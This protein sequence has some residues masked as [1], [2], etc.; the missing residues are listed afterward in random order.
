MN[1]HSFTFIILVE[2]SYQTS[3]WDKGH[4]GNDG[5]FGNNLAGEIKQVNFWNGELFLERAVLILWG[6]H[7][8]EKTL[9]PWVLRG[10]KR[11]VTRREKER[12][13]RKCEGL[14]ESF[15]SLS[16]AVHSTRFQGTC[17]KD[18][19]AFRE[20]S[21]EAAL[22]GYHRARSNLF[23]GKMTHFSFEQFPK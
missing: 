8:L 7:Y 10:L 3:R 4:F 5:E 9:K 14:E 12:Q 19:Q 11:E 20:C 18:D 15:T 21:G 13:K 1:S 2:F 6:F 23:S 17:S 22:W 16:W